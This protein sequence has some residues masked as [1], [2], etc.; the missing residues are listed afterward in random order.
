MSKMKLWISVMGPLLLLPMLSGCGTEP[1]WD[2]EEI[3]APS[4]RI[5]SDEVKAEWTVGEAGPSDSAGGRRTIRV[6]IE[7]KDGKPIESF[8]T[9]HEKLLHLM[10][11][12]KDLSYFNHI[13][14]EYKGNG[15]FEIANDFPSGGDYRLIADFKPTGGDTMTKMAWVKLDGASAAPVPVFPDAVLDKTFAGNRVKLTVDGL[16]A[17][18]ETTLA[19]SIADERTGRP[20]TD[21]E[22]YLGAIGHVVVLTEDGERYVHVHAEEGQG[23]GPEA[24]FETTFPKSGIYKI[25]AQFQRHGEVFTASF[26]VNVP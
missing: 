8:E 21:L 25:W 16:A 26:V 1:S 6:A 7:G 2:K 24:L 22:P 17:N 5:L 4:A 20:V 23:T 14:P 19:F 18:K 11:I 12:S 10:V 9:N 3:S 13:H 15:A